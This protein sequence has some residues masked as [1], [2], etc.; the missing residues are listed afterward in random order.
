MLRQMHGLFTLFL[1]YLYFIITYTTY[2]TITIISKI[3]I[4]PARHFKGYTIY[5]NVLQN[6]VHTRMCI[7][8]C[9]YIYINCYKL[10]ID[11]TFTFRNCCGKQN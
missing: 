9:T 2:F 7:Y 11:K 8:M 6:T 5:F 3:Y 10:T 4:S 1:L